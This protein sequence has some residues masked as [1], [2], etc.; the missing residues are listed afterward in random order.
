MQ[1]VVV[2]LDTITLFVDDRGRRVAECDS[3]R[4]LGHHLRA[5]LET[6]RSEDVVGGCPA[7]E[8]CVTVLEHVG[9]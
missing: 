3:L 6:G 2:V 7:K 9:L 5:P 1:V 4:S 8:R